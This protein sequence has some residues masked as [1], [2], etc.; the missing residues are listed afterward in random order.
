MNAV[1]A[2]YNLSAQIRVHPRPEIHNKFPGM[3]WNGTS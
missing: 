3:G 1:C 2:D